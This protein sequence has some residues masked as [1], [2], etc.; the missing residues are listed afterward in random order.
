MCQLVCYHTY[1]HHSFLSR[2]LEYKKRAYNLQAQKQCDAWI[3]IRILQKYE[4]TTRICLFLHLRWYSKNDL[5]QSKFRSQNLKKIFIET[6]R[7][8]WAP[9][10]HILTTSDLIYFSITQHGIWIYKVIQILS[11]KK[12]GDYVYLRLPIETFNHAKFYLKL[13]QVSEFFFNMQTLN[14]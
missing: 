5:N 11:E 4:Y 10:T 2:R 8:Q 12:S 3:C 9:S 1:S 13:E 7:V 14:V 6:L